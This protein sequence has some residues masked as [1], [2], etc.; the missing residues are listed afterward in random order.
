MISVQHNTYTGPFMVGRPSRT[1]GL[2]STFSMLINTK[3]TN[4]NI[5]WRRRLRRLVYVALFC[6]PTCASL[7]ILLSIYIWIYM[8][9]YELVHSGTAVYERVQ[10]AMW[11]IFILCRRPNSNFEHI[12]FCFFFRCCYRLYSIIRVPSTNKPVPFLFNWFDPWHVSN[13]AIT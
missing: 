7:Y 9:I 3:V 4:R 5:Y 6:M 12:L 1:R 13:V 2:T 11:T 8:N 10:R